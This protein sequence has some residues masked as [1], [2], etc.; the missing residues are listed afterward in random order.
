MQPPNETI[1]DL[2]LPLLIVVALLAVVV[3]QFMF[4]RNEF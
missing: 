3:C 4:N 1:C 2:Y